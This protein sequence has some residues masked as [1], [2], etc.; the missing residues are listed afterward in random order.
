MKWGI[1][2]MRIEASVEGL[3]L[4]LFI[5]LFPVVFFF[6]IDFRGAPL[7]NWNFGYWVWCLM[8]WQFTKESANKIEEVKLRVTY[9]A[10]PQPPSP[11]PE[12]SEEGSP[13]RV[14]ESENGDGPAG[15]FT[16]VSYHGCWT[17]RSIIF[18]LRGKFTWFWI[19]CR[20]WENAWA[21]RKIFRGQLLFSLGC[22]FSTSSLVIWL[23]HNFVIVYYFIFI[24]GSWHLVSQFPIQWDAILCCFL[25]F[26][27][28][29][30]P[31]SW[32]IAIVL[33]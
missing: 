33:L 21:S 11:V 25:W 12:E 19:H 18:S 10:P 5:F 28:T 14:S 1:T 17:H 6:S 7:L 4:E 23:S 22:D 20:H 30:F 29:L 8:A 32:I 9:V 24:F 2:Y 27:E 31:Y 16:R 26:S 13:S 15:G 3:F